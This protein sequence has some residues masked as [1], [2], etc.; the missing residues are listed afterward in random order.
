MTSEEIVKNLCKS[1]N[2]QDTD[3][4][5]AQL[6]MQTIAL[7]TIRIEEYEN[8]LREHFLRNKQEIHKVSASVERALQE[9]K[10]QRNENLEL[11]YTF[12]MGRG[13]DMMGKA[14]IGYRKKMVKSRK[15]EALREIEKK[16]EDEQIQSKTEF[17]Q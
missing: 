11:L 3:N 12:C 14:K 17:S 7:E 13:M 8:Y 15:L 16:V 5:S 6:L 10:K 9:L 4:Y 1:Y 2:L